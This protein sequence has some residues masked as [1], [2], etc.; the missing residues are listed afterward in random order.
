MRLVLAAVCLLAVFGSL[1]A[2][3]KRGKMMMMMMPV[4]FDNR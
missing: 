2:I 1:E 3:A 4:W